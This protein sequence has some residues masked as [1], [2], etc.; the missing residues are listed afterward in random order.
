MTKNELM[1]EYAKCAIDVEYFAR[2][3]CKVWDKKK[4]QYVAFQLLPQ[5]IQV[6]DKYKE[7]NRV[8]VAKY[9]QGGIT[10]VTCL[11]LAHSIVFRKDP[12][13]ITFA[14]TLDSTDA[15]NIR[16]AAKLV[17][18]DSLGFWNVGDYDVDVDFSYSYFSS[19]GIIFMNQT[20]NCDSIL[21]DFGDGA[22]STLRNPTHTYAAIG[23]Y[24][25]RLTS[26]NGVC[27]NTITI[28]IDVTKNANSITELN[29]LDVLTVYPNPANGSMIWLN[30]TG[31]VNEKV[32]VHL[33]DLTGRELISNQYTVESALQ[34]EMR[35][36]HISN[37]I[38]IVELIDGNSK[39]E[40][41]LVVQH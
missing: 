25:V 41:R 34:T 39:F 22:N 27:E 29:V 30:F 13:A 15:A 17:A 28:T 3:Y 37:G 18:Y 12:T 8:L 33:L 38:Y 2:K 23:S 7:S 24:T 19:T 11:Y 5:Q 6:L 36:D 31:L 35:I 1:M 40:Q 20:Q 26:G 4:Q 21:W 16:N 10:T 32:Q 14:S 9:R